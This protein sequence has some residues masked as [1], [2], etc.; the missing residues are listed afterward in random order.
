[1]NFAESVRY[2][3]TD[4][5]NQKLTENG[6]VAYSC[7]AGGPLLDF[8]A[9]AG[10][11]RPRTE[12]EISAKF[13]AAFSV[14]PL[15]ATK[16]LFYTGNIRGGLG[17]RRTFRTCLRWMAHYHPDI[18]RK[19]LSLI[20]LFNRWDSLFNLV[21]TRVE[22]D[23]WK[24]IEKQLKEDI[25]ALSANKSVSLLA[26]WMPS[27][28]TSS[29]KTRALAQRAMKKMNLY[30]RTYRKILSALRKHINVV[31]RQMSAQNWSEI[32]YATVPSYAMKNYSAAFKK[33]DFEGF[34]KYLDSVKKGEKKIN[35]STLY[36]YDLIHNVWHYNGDAQTTELQWKALPNYV[37]GE[38]NFIV[39][40]DVSGSM[41]GRPI[42]TSIGLATYFS[43]RNK[44]PYHNL[45]MT[46]SSQP[47]FITLHDSMTLHDKVA[48]VR[49]KGVGYST[50]LMAAF[51]LVLNHA[52]QN[53]ISSNEMPKAIIV[54]SDM[55]I[56]SFFH[57][58]ARWDFMQTARQKFANAGLAIPKLVLWNV[59]ARRDTFLTRE[60][61]V[62]LVSG[63]SAVTF[64]Q[65]CT[66]L[67]GKTNWDLMLETL[68]DKIYDCVVI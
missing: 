28:N 14:D 68:N 38:N 5:S 61:D 19:N 50:N 32:Q 59:E 53:N 16:M 7:S 6:A 15:L 51:D 23:M 3:S 41:Y 29:V 64:K 33:H 17:E 37:Q 42:E 18:V 34:S 4:I 35:A 12:Q 62:I 47:A 30:P 44:G 31:E 1:M 43:E 67:N 48:Y 39:M 25:T 26:K 58:N 60:E 56:D 9:V 10:A 2:N 63:Q 21:D 49:S 66:N 45:Y 27:Q 40:A 55:E 57:P 65:L 36:P 8:F 24:F 22:T 11:L 52:V 20:P 46:F 13:A 54:I